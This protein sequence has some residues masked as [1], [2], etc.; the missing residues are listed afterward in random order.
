MGEECDTCLQA[1]CCTEVSKLG[2]AATLLACTV[3][4]FDSDCLAQCFDEH[5]SAVNASDALQACVGDHCE[6]AC[7]AKC[8]GAQFGES[9]CGPC[10]L[11]SCCD[12]LASCGESS[13]CQAANLCQV[14]CGE[15]LDCLRDCN[16]K[17]AGGI[18]RAVAV[19]TCSASKCSSTG[20]AQ[21]CGISDYIEQPACAQCI[22]NKCC[23][24][25]AACG[26]EPECVELKVCRVA[27]K[28]DEACETGC[29]AEHPSGAALLEDL[30]ACKSASC[31]S[32][33]G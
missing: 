2:L 9:T 14:E 33:C 3:D 26:G 5:R 28:G 15:A 22:V 7:G 16:V 30:D 13:L 21:P 25:G 12:E 1:N 8:G 19:E 24:P 27:C 6:D 18:G 11:A 10:A 20:P 32:E 17:F 23:A 29:D 31:P 4:C